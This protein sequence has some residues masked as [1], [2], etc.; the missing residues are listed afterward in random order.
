ME[1]EVN[2]KDLG[3]ISTPL[4]LKNVLKIDNYNNRT[5]CDRRNEYFT[6]QNT[7]LDIKEEEDGESTT[8]SVLSDIVVY[9][10]M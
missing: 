10:P 3:T 4:T 9:Y 1:K 5:K 7:P 6:K 2:N 8:E